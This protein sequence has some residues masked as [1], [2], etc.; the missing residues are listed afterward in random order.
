MNL[1]LHRELQPRASGWGHSFCFSG[2]QTSSQTTWIAP[3]GKLRSTNTFSLSTNWLRGDG[4]MLDLFGLKT[5]PVHPIWINCLMI[6]RS[7]T[8]VPFLWI[9]IINPLS[10]MHINPNSRLCVFRGA[11]PPL[12][13]G[14]CQSCVCYLGNMGLFRCK[15]QPDCLCPGYSLIIQIL[16]WPWPLD[17]VKSWEKTC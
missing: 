7:I 10:F 4:F 15:L 17:Q 12:T 13:C 14:A 1:C 11:C 5:K 3:R 16:T 2:A 6:Q 9:I 8:S